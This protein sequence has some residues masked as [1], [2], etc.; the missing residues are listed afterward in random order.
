MRFVT[1]SN[2]RTKLECAFD[3]KEKL[4][5]RTL[6]A[7]ILLS[8]VAFAG[9]TKTVEVTCE[10]AIEQASVA[11]AKKHLVLRVDAGTM[12]LTERRSNLDNVAAGLAHLNNQYAQPQ[13]RP[14]KEGMLVFVPKGEQCEIT[15]DGNPADRVLKEITKPRP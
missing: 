9:S 14:L 6:S 3:E 2:Q 10:R 15:S 13:P 4:L 5:K 11:G 8:S 7:I 12:Y 1:D